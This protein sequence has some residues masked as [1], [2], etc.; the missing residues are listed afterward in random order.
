MNSPRKVEGKV[1]RKSTEATETIH[2]LLKFVR[3]KGID[4]VPEPVSY[5]A[6]YE[7]ISYIEGKVLHDMPMWAWETKILRQ[8][9]ARLRDWHDATLG[10]NFSQARWNFDTGTEHQVICHNDFAP[11][12]CVYIEKTMVGLIDFDLCAPGSR[13][14]DMAYA[15]YRFVPIMPN[16]AIAN[17]TEISP[18]TNKETN[19]R[20]ERFLDEYARGQEEMRYDRK[21]LLEIT[22]KRLQSLAEWT[23]KHAQISKNT[24]LEMHATM[25]KNHAD[26]ILHFL[27]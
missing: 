5:N 15:A 4:W 9:A 6:D 18:F 16:I 21:I 22:S 24:A 26:W 25:Y 19:L 7:V 1:W 17:E 23:K 20:I 10:F 14:W 8:T 2:Q 13:L 27:K 11:Y 12:N 3:T